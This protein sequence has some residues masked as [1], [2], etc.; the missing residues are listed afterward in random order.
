MKKSDLEGFLA[1]F[2]LGHYSF[3][4]K[5]CALFSDTVCLSPQVWDTRQ[6][7]CSHEFNAHEDYISGM[8]FASDSMKLVAT[9]FGF[10]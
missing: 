10:L 3:G 5:L 6:R 8:T 2:L 9:R 7:S 1:N 4:V